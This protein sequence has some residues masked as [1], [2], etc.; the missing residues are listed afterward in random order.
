VLAPAVTFYDVVL[1]IHIA[2]VVVAFGVTFAYPLMFALAQ[3]QPEHMTFTYRLASTIDRRLVTPTLGVIILAG[4]YLASK[5][6]FWGEFWVQWSLGAAIVLGGLVGGGLGPAYRRLIELGEGSG[7]RARE[8][9]ERRLVRR[10]QVVGG[11]A[12]TLVLVTI[13]VMTAKPFG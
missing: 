1:A 8:G 4:I 13:F 11:A 5:G 2:A 6:H 12:S 10:L 3:R 9:E 7:A